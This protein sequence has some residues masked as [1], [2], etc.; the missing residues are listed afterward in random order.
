[1]SLRPIVGE[2]EEQAWAKG[3][4]ILE[5]TRRRAEEYRGS[6][7]GGGRKPGG[8][9]TNEGSQRLLAFADQG[10]VHDGRLW[11]ALAKATGATGNSTA[12]V[13]TSEQVA[14]ALIEYVDAG[15]TTLLIRGYEPYADAVR[16]GEV[17]SIVRSKLAARDQDPALVGA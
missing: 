8:F 15:A 12:L 6:M 14:D 13:G 16:Y 7:F 3:R 11:T 1:M 5:T 2:T 10:E 4:E 17:I 9:E